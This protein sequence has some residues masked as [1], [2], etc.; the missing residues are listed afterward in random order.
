MN[1]NE[2]KL[3]KEI[4]DIIHENQLNIN[5]F[6]TGENPELIEQDN[7][8]QPVFIHD[9]VMDQEFLF[10]SENDKFNLNNNGINKLKNQ[11]KTREELEKINIR[12]TQVT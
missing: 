4:K 3:N 2:H 7:K 6:K 12:K 10:E 11:L 1:I 8:E 9:K 5:E